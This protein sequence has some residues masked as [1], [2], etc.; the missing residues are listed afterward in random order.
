MRDGVEVFKLTRNP[1]DDSETKSVLGK[2]PKAGQMAV[3]QS[4]ASRVFTNMCVSPALICRMLSEK[5]M[6]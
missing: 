2:S 5:L 1:E 3:G 6:Q 4:A